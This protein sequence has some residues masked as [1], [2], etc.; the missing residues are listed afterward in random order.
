MPDLTATHPGRH[1]PPAI[2]SN[3]RNEVTAEYI[4]NAMSD[5]QVPDSQVCIP[6]TQFDLHSE[7]FPHDDEYHRERIGGQESVRPNKEGISHPSRHQAPKKNT[8]TMDFTFGATP[9]ARPKARPKATEQADFSPYSQPNPAT[10]STGKAA[11][12]PALNTTAEIAQMSSPAVPNSASQSVDGAPASG[13]CIG[14]VYNDR[15][16]CSFRAQRAKHILGRFCRT[17]D[18]QRG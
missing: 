11:P 16:N 8:S 17:A 3:L 2:P 18:G 9:L 4:D 1:H 14:N 7:D 6:E 5:I 13:K 12:R 15:A 10:R